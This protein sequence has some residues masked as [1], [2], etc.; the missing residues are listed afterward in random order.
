M[1]KYGTSALERMNSGEVKEN[2]EKEEQ[3]TKLYQPMAPALM[4]Q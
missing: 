4:G 1:N 3:G 2:Q